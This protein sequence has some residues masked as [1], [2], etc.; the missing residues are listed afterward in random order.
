[1][2]QA[3]DSRSGG[4]FSGGKGDLGAGQSANAGRK[5]SGSSAFD[6]AD[7]VP[8]FEYV[9]RVATSMFR[10]LSAHGEEMNDAWLKIRRGGFGF[11]D[12]LQ[13]WAR[14]ADNYFGVVTEAA[15]GPGQFPRPAW[16]AVAVSKA[17]PKLP[18]S[19]RIEGSLEKDARLTSVWFNRDGQVEQQVICEE[20]PTAAGSRIEFRLNAETLAKVEPGTM[21][22]GFIL[23]EGVGSTSPLLI[24]MVRVVP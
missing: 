5:V 22:I 20:A 24:V 7:N 4:Y 23:R 19:I 18:H 13:S 3:Y 10:A 8:G 11:A 21:V 1:M 17:N 2:A 15:R 16:E 14:V 9:Q 6:A 12:A